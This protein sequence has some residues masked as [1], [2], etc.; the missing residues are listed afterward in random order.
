MPCDV[1]PILGSTPPA[2]ISMAARSRR[3]AVESPPPSSSA[4]RRRTGSLHTSLQLAH[5]YVGPE[6]AAPPPTPFGRSAWATSAAPRSCTWGR[7]RRG[8]RRRRPRGFARGR[9]RT[10]NVRADAGIRDER[11]PRG[12][13]RASARAVDAVAGTARPAPRRNEWPRGHRGGA[14]RNRVGRAQGT[15]RGRPMR[16][17]ASSARRTSRS[18]RDARGNSAGTRA[19]VDSAARTPPGKSPRDCA[20]RFSRTDNLKHLCQVSAQNLIGDA[21]KD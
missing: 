11:R 1:N 5:Q 2:P 21:A 17:G 15:P 9:R 7:A 18:A 13:G 4:A 3:P 10:R 19:R 8:R 12:V 14:R 6:S 16:L 20:R